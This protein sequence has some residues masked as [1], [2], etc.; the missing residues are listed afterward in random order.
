MADERMINPMRMCDAFLGDSTPGKARVYGPHPTIPEANGVTVNAHSNSSNFHGFRA[1]KNWPHRAASLRQGCDTSTPRSRALFASLFAF[2][3]CAFLLTASPLR[4]QVPAQPRQNPPAPQSP[5]P[6]AESNPFPENTTNV[7]VIPTTDV[8]A[9][10]VPENAGPPPAVP[11]DEA[12]PVRCPDDPAPE[13]HESGDSSSSSSGV[14]L[15][16]L[17]PSNDD[18]RRHNGKNQPPP[19]HAE[20]AKEDES[21]GNY[22]LSNLNWKGALSR[23]ESALVLDPENPDVYWGLAESQFHLGRFAAARANYQKVMEYDPDSK[24]AKEARKLL[25]EP[26]L[27]NAAPPP[28]KP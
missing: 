24:H 18:S 23:F 21:V 16:R 19:S 10:P 25:K 22:Y 15:A 27:A 28:A 7:P 13:V 9:P 5:Q 20:T 8:V 2:L 12:D 17:M 26:E 3:L 14:D 1:R 4:A 6:P 11:S